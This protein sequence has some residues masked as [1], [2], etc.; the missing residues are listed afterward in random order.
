M[1]FDH[2]DGRLF[3]DESFLDKFSSMYP[4]DKEQSGKFIS[5]WFSKVFDVDVM[6]FE[7]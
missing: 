2:S 6:F 5:D 1:E 4:L 3:I 7:Y